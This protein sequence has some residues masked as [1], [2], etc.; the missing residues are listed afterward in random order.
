MRNVTPPRSEEYTEWLR[1]LVQSAE[2]DDPNLDFF[3]GLWSYAIRHDGLT[4][5]Q[6]A[7]LRPFIAGAELTLKREVV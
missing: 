2:A 6:I 1:Y 4:P 3:V 5:K 7:A